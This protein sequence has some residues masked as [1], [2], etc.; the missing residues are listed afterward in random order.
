MSGI[1]PVAAAAIAPEIAALMAP[2]AAAATGVA[3][4]GAGAAGAG[5]L[6]AGA[7]GAAEAGAATGL[8]GAGTGAAAADAGLLAAAPEAA[9]AMTYVTPSIAGEA[10]VAEGMQAG[11]YSDVAGETYAAA[12]PAASGWQ[13]ALGRVNKAGQAYGKVNDAMGGQQQAAPP[14][15]ARPVFQGE[16]PQIAPQQQQR[17]GNQF[18]QMLLE[19]RRRGMLG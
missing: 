9:S 3:A 7:L 11:A 4:T 10:G 2:A 6:G 13:T 8:L 18:A 12:H 1:E 5:A 14:P 16:A 15:Q 19:Q 17:G